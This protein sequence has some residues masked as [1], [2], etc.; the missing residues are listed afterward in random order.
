M[1]LKRKI[2]L[3]LL[4]ILIVLFVSVI[5]GYGKL[6]NMVGDYESLSPRSPGER[7]AIPETKIIVEV[8]ANAAGYLYEEDAVW[9]I[10]IQY[11][12]GGSIFVQTPESRF[13]PGSSGDKLFARLM[14]SENPDPIVCAW[15]RDDVEAGHP[16]GD[17]VGYWLHLDCDTAVTFMHVS[18]NLNFPTIIA[19]LISCD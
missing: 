1:R 11:Q 18:E 14:Q 13:A 7:L 12:S 19:N 8:P 6:Q 15:V 4:V 16:G 3:V 5:F 10:E 9:K 17:Y 2:E